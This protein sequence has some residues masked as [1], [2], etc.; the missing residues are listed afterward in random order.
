MPLRKDRNFVLF[1]VL[2]TVSVAGDSLTTLA[3][4]VLVLQHTGSVFQMGLVTGTVGVAWLVSGVLSGSIVDRLDRRTVMIACD[5]A[6]A[7]LYALVPLVWLAAPHV[8]VL[9][10]AMPL[11]AAAGMLYQV[12]YI[13]AVP[14]LVDRD[15]ITHANGLLSASFAAASVTGPVIAAG[16]FAVLD[17]AWVIGVDAVTFG[18]SA[19]AMSFVKLRPRE[20]SSERESPI[21]GF[22]TG[23]RFLWRQPALRTL[24]VL[25]CGVV[26]VTY[27]L[28]DLL[29]F[30]LREDLGQGAGAVGVVFAI[31][32]AGTIVAGS[33]VAMLR[34]RLGFGAC[35]IGA[36]ALSGVAL[37]S[38]GSAPVVPVLAGLLA[39]IMFCQGVAGTCSMSLRQEITPDHLLGRVTSAF[40]TIHYLPGPIGAPLVTFAAARAGV[41]AVTLVLG[42]CLAAIAVIAAF[43]PLRARTF[44]LHRPAHG[45]AL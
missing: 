18:L 33:V 6:R 37:A 43:S 31:G 21:R 11:G 16:L 45:E 17:P 36:Y 25:L 27:S 44:A 23:A 24:T 8:W 28:D 14:A 30:R 38:A 9:Y 3:V 26:F 39:V 2:Q 35:W 34:R 40:W 4:P 41:P 15:Q 12:G 5:V 7:V 32:A 29:I 20:G 1:W 13:T 22:L 19:V 10:L 42:L